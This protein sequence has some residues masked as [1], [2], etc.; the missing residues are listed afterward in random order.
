MLGI[1]CSQH[2]YNMFCKKK[3]RLHEVSFS[4]WFNCIV[5]F[6]SSCIG[7]ISFFIVLATLLMR[8]CFLL[9]FIGCCHLGTAG[10]GTFSD[11]LFCT[12]MCMFRL[13]VCGTVS[14]VMWCVSVT[15]QFFVCVY[16]MSCL[17]CCCGSVSWCH[18]V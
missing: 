5:I 11:A 2:S 13:D 1:C 10:S 16:I 17:W 8:G 18:A 4:N 6:S 3:I 15:Q 12:T 7:V 14:V 9:C